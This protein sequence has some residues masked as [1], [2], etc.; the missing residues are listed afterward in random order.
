M[1]VMADIFFAAVDA[2][3]A[4][5]GGLYGED[6]S[7]MT[8]KVIIGALIVGG[9]WGILIVVDRI[10]KKRRAAESL[11][12]RTL[13]ADLCAVHRL[14]GPERK[15]MELATRRARVEPVEA[16]FVMPEVFDRVVAAD[17]DPSVWTE[18]RKKVYGEV[19]AAS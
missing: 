7:G 18:L 1:T 4:Y 14:S 15:R 17:R 16:L 6:D 8:R 2:V 13:F 9:I 10:Q 5:R 3:D 12:S 11:D 19:N